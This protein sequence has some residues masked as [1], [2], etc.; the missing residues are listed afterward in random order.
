MP[1]F[2]SESISSSCS[3][4]SARRREYDAKEMKNR[5]AR[6]AHDLEESYHYTSGPEDEESAGGRNSI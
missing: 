5:R 6:E 2:T 4:G 1:D 3:R